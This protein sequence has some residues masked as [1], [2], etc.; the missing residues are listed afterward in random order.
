MNEKKHID[1]ELIQ[2]L[3]LNFKT[4]KELKEEIRK[5]EQPAFKE[6]V[7]NLYVFYILLSYCFI[8]FKIYN[9][10]KREKVFSLLILYY[11]S[12]KKRDF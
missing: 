9:I 7:I 8:R 12:F 10:R 11:F 6:Q 4:I 3:K 1:K 2:K 5:F